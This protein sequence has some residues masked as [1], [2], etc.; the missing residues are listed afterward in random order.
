VANTAEDL[1]VGGIGGCVGGQQHLVG[2]CREQQREV[3]GGLEGT[4]S[5]LGGIAGD[6]PLTAGA[7]QLGDHLGGT[8]A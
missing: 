2:G 5:Q 1:P 4:L 7:H 3:A 6:V 8:P